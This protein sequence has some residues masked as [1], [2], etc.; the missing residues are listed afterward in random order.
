M[1]KPCMGSNHR[2]VAWRGGGDFLSTGAVWGWGGRGQVSFKAEVT[3]AG[4]ERKEKASPREGSPTREGRLEGELQH[5]TSGQACEEEPP[6]RQGNAAGRV[7]PHCR[8]VLP[9]RAQWDSAEEGKQAR[10]RNGALRTGYF[11]ISA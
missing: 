6:A 5:G 3:F 4:G 10:F 9:S 1:E 2:E 11:W 8:A 7:L